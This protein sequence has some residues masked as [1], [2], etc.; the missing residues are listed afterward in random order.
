V[1]TPKQRT[2]ARLA[3]KARKPLPQPRPQGPPGW[4][5]SG[6]LG[7]PMF[8][9]AF[10]S[11]RAPNPAELVEGFKAVV[12]SCVGLNMSGVARTRLALY[13]TTSEGQ[14]KPKRWSCPTRPVRP[15]V[16]AM[17][18]KSAPNQCE[19]WVQKQAAAA[20]VDEVVD[21]PLLETLGTVNDDFDTDSLIRY[22]VACGDVVGSF[23]VWPEASGNGPPDLL[24]PL[25]AQ[26][27]L[28]F[29]SPMGS[30]VQHYTYFGHTYQPAELIRGRFISLRDPYGAGYGP[31]QAAWSYVGLNDQFT[32]VQENLMT[33]GGRISGYLTD[34]DPANPLGPVEAAKAEQRI[35][36]SWTRGNAGRIPYF[37]GA[38][39]FEPTA[40]PPRDLAELQI[41]DNA[42]L[43]IAN[44]FGVPVS[45]LKT[46]DVNRANADAGHLQHAKLAVDPRCHLIA[47]AL[48]KWTRWYGAENG[49]S[50]WDR[51]FW[52]FD[53]PVS[54][55]KQADCTVFTS[56][57]DRG[58]LAR[59]EVRHELGYEPLDGADDLLVPGT[60]KTL[61]QIANPPE[62]PPQLVPPGM[63]GKPPGGKPVASA[64]D[65]DEPHG[66]GKKG[67]PFAGGPTGLTTK[68]N[69]DRGVPDGI[70][71]G[72]DADPHEDNTFGLPEGTPIK[73]ELR[74]WFRRMKAE[75]MRVLEREAA[76]LLGT[77][78][79][80]GVP[81]DQVMPALADYAGPMSSAMTP[82]LS[83]YWDEAGKSTRA[84]L[85]LD[86][87]DWRVVDPNTHRM[88]E[89]QAIALCDSTLATTD[90]DVQ[91]AY[92]ELRR[93]LI[94]GV[95][96]EGEGIPELTKRVKAVFQDAE[97]WRA[98]RI[99]R[100]EASRAVN[101]ASLE[102]AKQSGV[103]ARK[104]WLLSA[105]SCDRCHEVADRV[106]AQGGIPL[107]E[108]FATGLSDKPAYATAQTAPLHPGC[109]CTSDWVLDPAYSELQAA[110]DA[111]IEPG[112]WGP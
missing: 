112:P 42:L 58:I 61:D 22:L 30:L 50:G 41:S 11:R 63:G 86:P 68:D 92:A 69:P 53:N 107:D 25:L 94:A 103:V 88:I 19:G 110:A 85:G 71:P 51:L 73:R 6:W 111:P 40:W 96:A 49:L 65:D 66:E 72:D 95:V 89:E 97:T 23:Y 81:L 35:N 101:A 3:A 57:V 1:P 29:K 84:R 14:L 8:V 38:L 60:L 46:E 10:N 12:W 79:T 102:S 82:L 24:W 43:R 74:R 16:K 59:N 90:L 2:A 31:A 15:Q 18:R 80:I 5:G 56:Y 13:A 27:V 93:E 17:M 104:K 78:E 20:E 4:G 54:E 26:Y 36:A 9:D 70:P 106:N 32:S 39:K 21:H 47:S 91:T 75:Y 109:R 28:P 83:A 52:A 64:A 37:P 87:D 33:Q 45:L 105:N 98:E 76:R 7:G 62:P 44:C 55:D 48:T 100:T 77:A 108:P 99:A 34:A 67:R